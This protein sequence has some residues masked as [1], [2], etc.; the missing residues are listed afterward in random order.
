[1]VAASHD[2][3]RRVLGLGFVLHETDRPGRNGPVVARL[4][5]AIPDHPGIAADASAIKRALEIARQRGARHVC[6]RSSHNSTRRLLRDAS[7]GRAPRRP[8]APLHD[9]ILQL[10]SSFDEVRFAFQPRRQNDAARLLARRALL[11]PA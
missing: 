1:M 7:R 11:A 10:A 4:A 6:V 9:Q 2:A 5:E 3:R 8:A